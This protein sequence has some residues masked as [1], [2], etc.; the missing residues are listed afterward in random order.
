MPRS[1]LGSEEVVS[2]KTTPDAAAD[3]ELEERF[4]S[5]EAEVDSAAC[6]P[7]RVEVV[8]VMVGTFDASSNRPAVDEPP[9]ERGLLYLM[10]PWVGSLYLVSLAKRTS[11]DGMRRGVL[12]AENRA[13]KDDEENKDQGVLEWVV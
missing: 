6:S 9:V 12:V 13:V 11:L 3:R 7:N 5:W 4:Q 10:D 1:E 2:T 8:V